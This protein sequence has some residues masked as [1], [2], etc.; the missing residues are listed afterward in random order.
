ME[1][2]IL[3][4][5]IPYILGGIYLYVSQKYVMD[6]SG[7]ATEIESNDKPKIKP[8][9]VFKKNNEIEQITYPRIEE[10]KYQNF[11]KK[12]VDGD[13]LYYYFS[14]P[15]YGKKLSGRTGYIIVRDSFI[16]ENHLD[17]I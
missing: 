12:M 10:E 5:G 13:K 8:F 15:S 2:Q 6:I 4:Y 7:N 17:A 9:E 14:T 16:I 11:Y 1:W 3:L